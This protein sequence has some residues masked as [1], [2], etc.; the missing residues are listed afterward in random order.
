MFDERYEY[1]QIYRIKGTRKFLN[2]ENMYFFL[3]FFVFFER[4]RISYSWSVCKILKISVVGAVNTE[5]RRPVISAKAKLYTQ[6]SQ[7]AVFQ[8]FWHD[9]C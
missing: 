4:L 2:D 9:N 3:S 1:N 7:N 5:S 6:L 8:L